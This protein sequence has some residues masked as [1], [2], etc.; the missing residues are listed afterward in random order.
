M[1]YSA[2]PS[3]N[4]CP[5]KEKLQ[6]LCCLLRGRQRAGGGDP[7]V[8]QGSSWQSL[9]KPLGSGLAPSSDGRTGAQ[10][11]SPGSSSHMHGGESE[12][13]RV[14]WTY[15]PPWEDAWRKNS[16]S[17]EIVWATSSG[18][19]CTLNTGGLMSKLCCLGQKNLVHF[20]GTSAGISSLAPGT[21]GFG[22]EGRRS[23]GVRCHH[24]GIHLPLSK[25]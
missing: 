14:A 25:P 18:S 2:S 19:Q 5:S 22:P 6:L 21:T 3:L 23:D 20:Q 7:P 12:P 11:S 8:C 13:G 9:S 10:W 15:Q 16:P 4:S 17:L 24:G 1:H